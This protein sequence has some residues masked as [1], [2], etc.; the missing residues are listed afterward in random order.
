MSLTRSALGSWP[1]ATTRAMMSRSVTMATTRPPSTTG[2]GPFSFW[3]ISLAASTTV[4][5][6]EAV[7]GSGVMTSRTLGILLAPFNQTWVH[8]RLYPQQIG[9]NRSRRQKTNQT[10]PCITSDWKLPLTTQPLP[11]ISADD[12]GRPAPAAGRHPWA[13]G[14]GPGARRG[15]HEPW[16][17]LGAGGLVADRVRLASTGRHQPLRPQSGHQGRG[18]LHFVYERPGPRTTRIGPAPA[19]AAQLSF[20]STA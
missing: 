18:E 16:V 14:A 7:A 5:D 15:R 4:I 9:Q 3:I 11:W 17:S 10:C 2:S 12:P 19:E 1:A 6:G 13:G 8:G 20:R